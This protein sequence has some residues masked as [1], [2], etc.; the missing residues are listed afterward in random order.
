M[1]LI[2]IFALV[3]LPSGSVYIVRFCAYSFALCIFVDCTLVALKGLVFVREAKVGNTC[4][5]ARSEL[6]AAHEGE[7]ERERK[8]R[9][10]KRNTPEAERREREMMAMQ[11]EVQYFG[12]EIVNA[13]GC[14]ERERGSV[15]C[16]GAERHLHHSGSVRYLPYEYGL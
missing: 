2:A 9:E 7:W 13:R 10:E 11:N 5:A 15:L 4:G 3:Y 6:E 12:A 8:R 16:F 1:M 14:E